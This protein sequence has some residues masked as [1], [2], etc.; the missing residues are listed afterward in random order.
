MK[1]IKILFFASII[2]FIACKSKNNGQEN[3]IQTT[4]S[5]AVTNIIPEN[6]NGKIPE[7]TM[8]LSE[9]QAVLLIQDFHLTNRCA[10]CKAIEA[11]ARKTLETYFK[12]EITEGRIVFSIIDVDDKANSKIAEKYQAAG[13]GLFITRLLKGKEE[14][15]DL[16]EDGFS[17]ARNEE[18]KFIEI[19]KKQISEYLK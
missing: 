1:T 19:L 17:Y 10:T 5:T 13:S 8:Q 6:T 11:A 4:D 7:K 14:T 9:K 18:A 15:K 2:L 16:T 12:N 3:K